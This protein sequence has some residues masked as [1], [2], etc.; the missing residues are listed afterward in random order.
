M[1][2]N[3]IVASP[4]SVN[5]DA[6]RFRDYAIA[7]CVDCFK[8]GEIPLASHLHYPQILSELDKDLRAKLGDPLFNFFLAARKVVFY[9]DHGWTD[10]MLDTKHRTDSLA[11]STEERQLYISQPPKRSEAP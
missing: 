7:C 5:T 8:R 2:N 3:V 6:A 11:Y 4:F 1:N 9:T 10:N